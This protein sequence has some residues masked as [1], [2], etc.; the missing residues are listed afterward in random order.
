MADSSLIIALSTILSGI[1]LLMLKLCFKSK[2]SDISICFGLL[3]IK[4]DVEV[5]RKIEEVEI[6]NNHQ[7][8]VNNVV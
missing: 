2:C 8:D 7:D 4:R 5:E 6:Q 3:K 1:A